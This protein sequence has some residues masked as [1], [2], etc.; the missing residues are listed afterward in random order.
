MRPIPPEATEV[1]GSDPLDAN[2]APTLPPRLPWFAPL[3]RARVALGLAP[4]TAPAVIFVPVGYLLGPALLNVLSPAIL[5][6]LGPLVAVSLAALGVFVGLALDL[7]ARDE[8]PLLVAASVEAIATVGVVAL[9]TGFLFAQ[10]RLELDLAAPFVAIALGVCASASSATAPAGDAPTHQ[11][12]A[13]RIAD[14]DDVLPILLG[15]ILL[16]A[17]QADDWGLALKLTGLTIV[18]GLGIALAGWLLFERAHEAG[19]RGVFVLG[20]L[21]LLGGTAAYLEL[22]PLFI[23]LVAGLYWSYSPGGADQV[24]RTEVRRF[25]HPLVV[26]LLLATG[27]SLSFSTLTAWLL[28][29][30]IAF[31][32]AGKLLGG[33][34]ATKVA[35]G[36]TPTDLGAWLVPPGLLGL[37]FALNFAQLT[38][39]A[40]GAAVLSAVALG[41]LISEVAGAIVLPSPEGR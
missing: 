9:A 11:R 29:P 31:R 33:W 19:E 8:R 41:T 1:G 17:M 28:V 36:L 21:M 2:L 15:G 4:L 13:M 39:P 32:L 7:R 23:G 3:V 24:I 12:A 18:V 30:Y 34:L 25:Q 14:L 5:S 16:A 38:S 10:W 37:A 40:T 26:L 20:A 22:S 35:P 27:A 6:H